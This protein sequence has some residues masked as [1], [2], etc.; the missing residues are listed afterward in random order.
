MDVEEEFPAY[1][2]SKE[3][4]YWLAVESRRDEATEDDTVADPLARDGA[5]LGEDAEREALD[6]G[7]EEEEEED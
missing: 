2:W 5:N 6:V 1:C 4:P 7:E 3:M